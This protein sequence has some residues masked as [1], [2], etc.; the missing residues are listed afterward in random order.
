VNET[1]CQFDGIP[2]TSYIVKSQLGGNQIEDDRSNVL[3]DAE[4][5]LEMSNGTLKLNHEFNVTI[6]DTDMSIQI[7]LAQFAT[8][9]PPEAQLATKAGKFIALT[10]ARRLPPVELELLR[11]AYSAIM[12][13][14]A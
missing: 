13:D 2:T 10:D 5:R 3:I 8:I 12:D 14:L 7:L 11:L 6:A 4:Q 9:D 1:V